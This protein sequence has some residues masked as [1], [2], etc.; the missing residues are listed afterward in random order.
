MTNH[1]AYGLMGNQ[2]VDH[3]TGI[4]PVSARMSIYVRWWE[5]NLER[6]NS[7]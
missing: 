5:Y 2:A 6:S 4:S 1:L 3:Y 7:K